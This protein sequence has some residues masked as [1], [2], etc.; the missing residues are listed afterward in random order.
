MCFFVEKVNRQKHE[1]INHPPPER[2]GEMYRLKPYDRYRAASP[3]LRKA[4]S[5]LKF[6][7]DTFRLKVRR[8]PKL[9]LRVR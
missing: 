3:E 7:L 5:E 4:Q 1:N 8:S 2:E 6:F 9:T